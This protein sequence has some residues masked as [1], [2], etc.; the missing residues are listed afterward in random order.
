[1]TDTVICGYK[2]QPEKI[3]L[4]ISVYLNELLKIEIAYANFVLTLA[5]KLVIGKLSRV[6]NVM[7]RQIYLAVMPNTIIKQKNP[8]NVYIFFCQFGVKMIRSICFNY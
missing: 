1:M 6:K 4:I 8:T 3:T 5:I 7:G 2:S